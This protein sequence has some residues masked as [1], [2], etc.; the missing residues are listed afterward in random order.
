MPA[1][2]I[3]LDECVHYDLVD[4]LRERGF[5]VVAARDQGVVGVDDEA[6]LI[7]ASAHGWMILT[8]NRNHFQQLHQARHSQGQ[9][10][11]GIIVMPQSTAAP[12]RVVRTAM[13]LTWISTLPEHETRSR[14][15]KWGQLQELLEQGFR[16][17]G[18][19]EE[20]VRIVLA[21]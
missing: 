16:L 18:Y 9:P 20:D 3:Y 7:Y 11:A 15:F 2:S 5:S 6:Q 21:R 10:H 13:M 1:L 8:Y 19:D 4:A 12:I 17:P 14:L